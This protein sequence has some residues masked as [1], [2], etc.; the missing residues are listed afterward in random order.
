MAVVAFK[1]AGDA[2][3]GVNIVACLKGAPHLKFLVCGKTGV[4]KSSLINSFVGREVC[5]VND[6]GCPNG[7]FDPG[8]T[9]VSETL[10]KIGEITVTFYD[11]PGLQDC[12]NDEEKYLQDMYG[13]CKDVDLVLY[14]ME[15]TATRYTPA[16]VQSIKLVGNTFGT[17]IWKRCVLVMT[18]ANMVR[19]SPKQESKRA[20]HQQLYKNFLQR[21]RMQLVEQGVP[22]HAAQSIPAV[23]AGYYD[24]KQE[25]ERYVWYVSDKA[26]ETE[27]PVDY[28]TELWVTCFET[29]SGNSRLNF[30]KATIRVKPESEE[31]QQ[32]KRKIDDRERQICKKFEEQL[33]KNEQQH[34]K[35]LEKARIYSYVTSS[36]APPSPP[37]SPPSPRPHPVSMAAGAAIGGAVG[38][39]VGAVVGAAVGAVCNLM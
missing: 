21:F 36:P 29:V 16:D 22:T 37:P 23:A 15:M 10:V 32:C 9:N 28:L 13:K 5:K 26:E 4:G 17:E 24:S 3:D 35:E 33:H 30:L 18:K 6:P 7:S 34:R 8:T 19:E 1:P 2:L 39:P 25:D 14:C 20:Y 31:V 27:Q 38:G 11:S 12:T